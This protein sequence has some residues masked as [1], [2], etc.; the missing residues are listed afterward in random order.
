MHITSVILDRCWYTDL[1]GIIFQKALIAI[2]TAMLTLNFA[3]EL[4]LCTDEELKKKQNR[5]LSVELNSV[6]IMTESQ[7]CYLLCNL[8]SICPVGTVCSASN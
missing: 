5:T 6:K 3:T 4:T 2:D 1:H 7:Q 8:A